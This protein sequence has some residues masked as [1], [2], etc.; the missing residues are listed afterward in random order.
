MTVGWLDDKGKRYYLSES[1]AML[2]GTQVIDGV[3]YRFTSSG[4]L[5]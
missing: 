5:R 1:G 4:A 3:E 2:T